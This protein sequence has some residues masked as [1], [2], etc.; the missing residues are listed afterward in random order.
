[1]GGAVFRRDRD[2]RALTGAQPLADGADLPGGAAVLRARRH[3]LGRRRIGGAGLA[4]LRP[5]H[6][7]AT[8]R[9]ALAVDGA[10]LDLLRLV[11]VPVAAEPARVVVA[12]PRRGLRSVAVARDVDGE[13]RLVEEVL[14][15]GDVDDRRA[16]IAERR[17]PSRLK[18][19]P[20]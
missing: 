12:Q 5:R 4:E 15:F 7:D 20:P 13:P 19:M 16:E 17:L 18:A 3:Q 14:P 2:G 9:K 8:G 6:E 11:V 1:V 10:H